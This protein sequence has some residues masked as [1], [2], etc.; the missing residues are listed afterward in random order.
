MS[1]LIDHGLANP[2]PILFC[3]GK[4]SEYFR[5]ALFEKFGHI[6]ME[7][8]VPENARMDQEFQFLGLRFRKKQSLF[9]KHKIKI[10]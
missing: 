5:P 9:I 1:Q 4:F 10:E 8:R 7:R 6:R 2:V 3:L